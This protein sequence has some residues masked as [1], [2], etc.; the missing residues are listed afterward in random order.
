MEKSFDNIYIKKHYEDQL[1]VKDAL[2]IYFSHYHFKD[3][4]YKDKWFKIKIGPFFLPLPNIKDRVDAVK[5][6]DIHHVITEYRA[7]YK[8]EVQIGAW[9]IASGCGKYYIAWLLNFGSFVIGI[10][11]FF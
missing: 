2:Q 4:G 5:I 7:D 11:F 10:F 1:L 8:G 9:E 6:H 3:G